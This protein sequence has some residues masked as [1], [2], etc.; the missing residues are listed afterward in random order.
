MKP[1]DLAIK[2]HKENSLAEAKV[3][4]KEHLRI[5]PKDANAKQLLG[6]IYCVEGDFEQA[7]TILQESLQL[8]PKQPHVLT[9][10]G[11][12][13]QQL[14][15]S[16][17][18]VDCYQQAINL[19][20][21]Y[22]EAYK[23]LALCYQADG[24]NK[25][26]L[27]T[28]K[29][30]L[31]RAP[32]EL[33][34]LKLQG[35]IAKELE[36][37]PISIASYE[38]VLQLKPEAAVAR[39]NLAVSL[40]LAGRS[41]GALKHYLLLEKSGLENSQLKHNIAN[42][43]SDLGQL[44]EA[45][46]YFSQAIT[47]NIGYVASHKNLNNLLWE[48]NDH[49]LFLN[50]Y[51]EAMLIETENLELHFSYT[52]F[53][54]RSSHY[55]EAHDFLQQLSDS[56]RQAPEYFDLLARSLICLG[57]KKAALVA[58]QQ[59]I[60]FKEVSL[61]QR[62]N[63]ARNLIEVGDTDAAAQQLEKVLNLDPYDQMAIAYLAV[64]WRLKGDARESQINNYKELVKEYH[65]DSI[66]DFD[67]VTSFCIV[68]KSYLE[69]LHSANQQP[70]EQTLYKGTQTKANLFDNKNELIQLFVE[71]ASLCIEDYKHQIQRIP[72][73]SPGLKN[74]EQFYFSGSWSVKLRE[75][76]FHVSHVHP[77]GRLS[78]CFY[79]DLP[80][81]VEESDEHQGWFKVGE[82][83]LDLEPKL[84]AQRFVKPT[85]GKL[86]IFP[87]YMWHGTVPFHTDES[88]LTIAFDVA[89]AK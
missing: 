16:K 84:E 43:Y 79:I 75:Q 63:Y 49:Q 3:Q 57:D 85:V 44:K 51:K 22:F 27:D 80:V 17:Q 81:I 31:T 9:N 77:M 1:I 58:Q 66:G 42:A 82:P 72:G 60:S 62:V 18:A 70:L 10:L 73:I 38:K 86:V 55:Q 13:K 28:L 64:C 14:G 41:E 19:N 33:N 52:D 48:L 2:A 39:H 12:C 8:N 25:H 89:S 83:N 61:E 21:D 32:N 76:G 23:N 74:L 59:A 88:R 87:S 45:V 50:S 46:S 67:D 36:D 15:D 65:F 35:L 26:A 69:T 6:L 20:A 47:L 24:E 30:A 40:R 56:F 34:L 71:K 37:Y 78:C 5:F 29:K 7:E 54:L 53:L 4:Y 11:N 68:L